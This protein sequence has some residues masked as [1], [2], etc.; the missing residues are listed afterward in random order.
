MTTE[1]TLFERNGAPVA[2]IA[3]DKEGT[4]YLWSG[5]AVAYLHK[6]HVYG[7]NGEHLGWFDAEVM[8]DSDGAKVGFTKKTCPSITKIEPIKKIKKIKKIKSIKTIAPI[9][10]INKMGTSDESLVSVLSQGAK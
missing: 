3:D 6:E 9:R 1:T 5:D 2:Y 4:I 7:F 8:R 10:P